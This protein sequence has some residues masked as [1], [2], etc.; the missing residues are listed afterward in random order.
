MT[1]DR[2]IPTGLLLGVIAAGERDGRLDGDIGREQPERNR[3]QLLGAALGVFGVGTGGVEAP[4]DDDPRERFD[5]RVGAE[6]DQRDRAGD[7]ARGDRDRGLD[8]VPDQAGAGEQPRSGLE[9]LAFGV[10]RLGSG[11]GLDDGQ[12][13]GHQDQYAE[14]LAEHWPV[15]AGCPLAVAVAGV[16][17]ERGAVTA[18]GEFLRPIV[19]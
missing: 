14:G 1:I 10:G 3:D 16:A 18:D 17:G 7:G 12:L 11:G 6:R 8:T 9:P 5:Q 2:P 13:D 4:E 15:L 19:G